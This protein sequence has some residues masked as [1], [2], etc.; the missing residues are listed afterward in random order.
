MKWRPEPLP[1][2]EWLSVCFTRIITLE[3]EA[4][5]SNG[6][7]NG[8]R[9]SKSNQSIVTMFNITFS[10]KDNHRSEEKPFLYSHTRIRE[11]ILSFASQGIRFRFLFYQCLR[12]SQ[13]ISNIKGIVFTLFSIIL[14][15]NPQLF[16]LNILY[17]S[18]V[19][20]T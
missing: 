19:A 15:S 3:W 13:L 10:L 16:H 11:R 6:S 2:T 5:V 17:S 1:S 7:E 8:C 9:K 14:Q 18:K 4:M 12:L 20:S